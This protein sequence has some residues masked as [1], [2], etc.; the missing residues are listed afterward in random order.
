M[1]S[2]AGHDPGEM[3]DASCRDRVLVEHRGDFPPAV[4]PAQLDLP[5]HHEAEEQ[6]QRRVFAGQR[7]LRL[8][9]PAKLL[10]EPL[11]RVRGAQRLPLPFGE[12]EER[13]QF[14]AAFPKANRRSDRLLWVALSRVWAGWRQAL[15]IVSPNTVLRWQRR[16]FREYWARLSARPA[17]GRPRVSCQIR[18]LVVRMAQA[19]PLWGAPRIHGELQMLGIDVAERTLSRLVPK[20]RSPPSQNV[21][22]VPDQSRP[23]PR[24]HRFLHC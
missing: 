16:R 20:R 14:V 23:G 3:R 1:A 17:A 15:V 19:N 9:A 2:T 10:V 24:L 7:A 13:E 12:G 22:H 4:N 21:A 11:D 8:H 5:T 18:A 6:G